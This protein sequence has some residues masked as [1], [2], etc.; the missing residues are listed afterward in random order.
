MP[1]KRRIQPISS[2]PLADAYEREFGTQVRTRRPK[3]KPSKARLPLNAFEREFE[4][5]PP[6]PYKPPKS[7]EYKRYAKKVKEDIKM[8][9]GMKA[10][11]EKEAKRREREAKQAGLPV[12]KRGTGASSWIDHVKKVHKEN[13]SMTYGGAMKLASKSWKK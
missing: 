2:E 1:P 12:M 8:E 5:P 3:I 10:F 7:A 9:E 11:A 13:P 6:K 4:A